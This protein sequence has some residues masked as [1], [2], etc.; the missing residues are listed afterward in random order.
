[1]IYFC[2]KINQTIK[3]SKIMATKIITSVDEISNEEVI[4]IF[5]E[6]MKEYLKD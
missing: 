1:M 5:N 4:E 2:I 6:I 3:Q